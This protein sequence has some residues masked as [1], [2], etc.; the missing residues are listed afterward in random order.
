MQNQ[1]NRWWMQSASTP[2]AP[3]ESGDPASPVLRWHQQHWWWQADDGLWYVAHEGDAW[4]Y[5]YI[6]R[7][8]QEGLVDTKT[9]AQMVY[10]DDGKVTVFTPGQGGTVYAAASGAVVGKVPDDHAGKPSAP[11]PP[12]APFPPAPKP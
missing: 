3:G 9:G 5:R 11:I 8:K 4:A 2:K 6:S 1:G 10:S 7:W 12:N